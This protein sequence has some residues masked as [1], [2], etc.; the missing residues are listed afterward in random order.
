MGTGNDMLW[1]Q[2][3]QMRKMAN[4]LVDLHKYPPP[5]LRPVVIYHLRQE[6]DQVNFTAIQPKSS[7][8]WH[9]GKLCNNP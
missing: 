7:G 8:P 5:L 2:G 3:E 9:P 4:Q 6:G 1:F